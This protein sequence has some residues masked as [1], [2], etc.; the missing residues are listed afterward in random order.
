MTCAAIAVAIVSGPAV[1][2]PPDYSGQLFGDLGGFRESFAKVG[3][4][5]SATENSE[6]FAKSTSGVR[7]GADYDRST[8]LT[9][10]LDSKPAFGF[11]GGQFNASFLNLH[12]DNFTT[13]NIGALLTISGVQ[14]DRA[15]RAKAI[16][17]S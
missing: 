14:G 10:Q 8:T 6:V 16:A 12:G 11:E 15:T 1:A 7:R 2:D 13:A 5:L 17:I 3:G 9:V 4:T